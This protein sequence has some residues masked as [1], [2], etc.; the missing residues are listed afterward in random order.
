MYQIRK[1]CF[2][3]LIATY[4]PLAAQ[5]IPQHISYYKIYEF[6]DEL[7]NEGLIDLN[8]AIKPYSQ[9][10]IAEKLQE[11]AKKIEHE[12]NIALSNRQKKE[13]YF[14]LNEFSLESDKLPKGKIKLLDNKENLISLYPPVI[15][16]KNENFKA[17]I[18]PILGMHL[19]YNQHG[20]ID[21]RWYG[22]EFQSQIG[23]NISLWGSLRD[24]SH[25]SVDF[26]LSKSNYL[27]N[28]PG[29]EYTIG[30]DFSDSRGGISY[31]NP[32]FYIGFMKDNINW[33]DNY[34]GSNILSGR[35]PSFPMLYLNVKPA[36]WFEL[37]YFH[38]W[39]V[40]NVLDSTYHY[41]ENDTKIYYRPANK[42]IAANLLTF[43][44]IDKLKL[45]IGNSIVYAERNVIP[46]YFIPIAFYKSLDHVLT[47][48]LGTENQNSQLFFNISSRNIKHL[49]LYASLFV[50]EFQLARLSSKRPD[51]NPISYKIGA[52]TSGFPT[53]DLA[54]GIEYTRTNIINYKHSIPTLTYASNSYNL[55]H[56]LCDNSEELHA[57]VQYR[58]IR[59]LDINMYYT[60]AKHGNEYEYIRRGI[61]NGIKQTAIDIISQPILGDII[62]KNNTFGMR[63]TYEVFRNS[64]AIVKL[65]KSNI[66]GFD[67]ESEEVFGEIRMSAQEVLDRFTPKFLHGDNLTFTMGFSFGF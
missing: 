60:H 51:N 18:T 8:S 10:M 24:I 15:S 6:M 63:A 28:E 67:A 7:A 25:E 11:V 53:K 35:A 22:A 47:K 64:Y 30:K 19:T 13:L 59:G 23:K 65:E 56:Y 32:Y 62:W 55:G 29:Y 3:I 38:G 36:K 26:V 33:G 12:R 40:S 50:D 58:P 41:I 37:N 43:T 66:Q 20:H 4:L 44:P 16:Y 46:S 17:R 48:G 2:F 52:Q 9:T 54:A 21:K 1:Y 45:S 27:N 5:N 31:H 57:F 14:Y 42:Y 49:H 61:F 39:L 34:H